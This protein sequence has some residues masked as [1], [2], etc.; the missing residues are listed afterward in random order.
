MQNMSQEFRVILA[1]RDR[2]LIRPPPSVQI[3]PR[4]RSAVIIHRLIPPR[5]VPS[6][7]EDR[8]ELCIVKRNDVDLIYGVHTNAL[9]SLLLEDR[10]FPTSSLSSGYFL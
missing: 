9:L 1:K 7:T 5:I 4:F 10:R 2:R 3:Y 6:K 8:E